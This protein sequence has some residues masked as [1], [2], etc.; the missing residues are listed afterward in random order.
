V[1]DLRLVRAHFSAAA[2]PALLADD[3]CAFERR[4]IAGTPDADLRRVRFA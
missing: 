4:R 2:A 1:P 3:G